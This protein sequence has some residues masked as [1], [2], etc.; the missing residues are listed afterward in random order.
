MKVCAIL[1]LSEGEKA[2]NGT[3]VYLNDNLFPQ[4]RHICC[5]PA[6][7]DVSLVD[8]TEQVAAVLDVPAALVELGWDVSAHCAQW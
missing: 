8:L 5:R 1:P 7:K 6:K 4:Q 2:V 3:V